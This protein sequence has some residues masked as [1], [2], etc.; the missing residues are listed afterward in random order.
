[1]FWETDLPGSIHS[2]FQGALQR[3]RFPWVLTR[4]PPAA[5][6]LPWAAGPREEDSPVPGEPA[7]G[8]AMQ[9]NV[10][11]IQPTPRPL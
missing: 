7:E 6:Q 8:Q 3:G 1:M 2:L 5:V 11:H 9:E 4:I 10:P